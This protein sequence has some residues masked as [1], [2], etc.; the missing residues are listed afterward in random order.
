MHMAG[1]I[2]LTGGAGFIGSAIARRL[3][4]TGHRTVV[5]DKLTYAGRKEN[6]DGVNVELVVGDVCDKALI[7][8]LVDGAD[9]VIHAAAESHVTRSLEDGSPFIRTNIE[10]SRVVVQAAADASVPHCIHLSTDEVFGPAAHGERFTIHS[11]HRPSNAYA[12]SKSAAEAFIRSI[13]HRSHY[14]C[15]VVRMTNNYGPRQHPEKAIP[16]W[17]EHA[18][19]NKSIPI[20]GK[21]LAERDWLH[22]EDFCTGILSVLHHGNPG[23]IHHFSGGNSLPN[24]QVA[25]KIAAHCGGQSIIEGPERPGQDARYGLDDSHTRE[26]LRW[27]PRFNFD[28]GLKDLIDWTRDGREA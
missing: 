15:S 23:E 8:E 2:L 28:T 11:P 20:H 7:R 17:I 1:H 26:K 18:L 25:E 6:L 4:S 24:R 13:E 14:A 9:A 27:E 22:V 5:V 10:G 21:G 3:A 16:C 19:D 12:A